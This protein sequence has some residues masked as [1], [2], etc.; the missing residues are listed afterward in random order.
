MIQLTVTHKTDESMPRGMMMTKV[1][2]K[3]KLMATTK[4]EN[5]TKGMNIREMTTL[6][7]VINELNGRMQLKSLGQLGKITA[8][9]SCFKPEKSVLMSRGS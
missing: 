4:E 8:R 6:M 1:S 9:P 2:I 5:M 3:I 7:T